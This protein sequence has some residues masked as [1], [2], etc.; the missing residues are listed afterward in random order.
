MSI[1]ISDEGKTISIFKNDNESKAEWILDLNEFE[2][3][4]TSPAG[5]D[6]IGF[7]IQSDKTE[8]EF[9]GENKKE[10]LEWW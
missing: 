8:V 9:W 4:G 5:K 10:T 2:V 1:L 3:L 7:K 6:K